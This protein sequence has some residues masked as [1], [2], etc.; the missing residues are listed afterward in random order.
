MAHRTHYLLILLSLCSTPAFSQPGSQLSVGARPAILGESF[1]AIADDGYAAYWNPAGLPLL[2][3][4]EINAMRGDLYNT[5]YIHSYLA[6]AVPFTDRFAASIDYSHQGFDDTELNFGQNRLGFA[7][8]LRLTNTLSLGLGAKWFSFDS[9]LA[10]LGNPSGFSSNGSGWGFDLGVLYEALPGFKLGVMAQDINDTKITYENG[11]SE[12]LYPLNLRLGAAYRFNRSL[13]L[14]TGVGESAQLGAEYRLHPALMLRGGVQRE[15]EDAVGTDFS[16]GAGMRHRFVLVDYAF[17]QSAALGPTHRFSMGMAFNLSASAIKIQD[18]AL[19]PIFPALQKRYVQQPVGNVRLTNTS[20]KP[21]AANVSLFIPEVMAEATELSEPVVIPP[22]S[23]TVDLFALF[24]PQLSDWSRNRILPAEVQVAYTDGNRTRSTKKQGQVT[25]YKRNAVRWETIGAA[26]AF[27]SPA[28]EAVATFASG[29]L[30]PYADELKQGGR[31]SRPLLRAMLLFNAISQHGVRYLADPNMPYDQLE[32]QDFVVDSIQY[33]A[34]LLQKRA[35]DCDDCTVLYC[36]LL[37]NVGIPTAVIDAPGHILMAFDTGVPSNQAQQ[38]GLTKGYYLER[39]GRLW[40]PVEVTLFGKSFHEAWRTAVEE[41][42]H[43]EQEGHL[44]VVDTQAA[45]QVYPPSDPS[46]DI[47][48]E[49]PAKAEVD[50]LWRADWQALR[51]VQEAYLKQTYLT[52]LHQQPG[53]LPLQSAFVFNLLQLG[54][55]GRAL[56]QLQ[57]LEDRGAPAPMIG[58]NRAIV[59]IL[60]GALEQAAEHLERVLALYPEDPEATAN[61]ALVQSRRGQVVAAREV[62]GETEQAGQRGEEIELLLEELRWK[63]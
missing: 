8:G 44:K 53:N 26:A 14:S 62:S 1:V 2:R 43:L 16:V 24:S 7:A 15:R 18:P 28:D 51:E 31:A 41:C 29:V 56:A 17:T 12:T 52:E 33:P 11:V 40:I 38:M 54:H 57:T 36:S 34:E 55:Y 58:N 3:S 42:L 47:V 22:G 6:Y 10:D 9:G 45:W 39:D 46:F 48:V 35:G 50:S 59:F 60:Q 20:R 30:H 23:E 13:L 37:E 19:A 21:L 32:G 5:D 63:K 61:L 27:I 49:T 25:V 4:Q